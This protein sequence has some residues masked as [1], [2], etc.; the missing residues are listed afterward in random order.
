MRAPAS[1]VAGAKRAQ[2]ARQNMRSAHVAAYS[3]SFVC[4]TALRQRCAARV[5][6]AR[7]GALRARTWRR[8]AYLPFAF[9]NFFTTPRVRATPCDSFILL[10]HTFFMLPP[11]HHGTDSNAHATR[12]RRARFR[13][14]ARA[15]P[16]RCALA[17]GRRAWRKTACNHYRQFTKQALCR[18]APTRN[19]SYYYMYTMQ[20][21]VLC[22]AALLATTLPSVCR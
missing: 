10:R 6:T 14:R 9:P 1:A 22:I 12:A 8:P 15:P 20:R 13:A 19:L 4:A 21:T 5:V 7:F 11:T 3:R 18:S 2:R 16:L 17:L